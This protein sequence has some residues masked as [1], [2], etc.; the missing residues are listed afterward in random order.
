MRT[1]TFVLKVVLA[2]IFSISVSGSSPITTEVLN[3]SKNCRVALLAI[4]KPSTRT[5]GCIPT[6]NQN[7]QTYPKARKLNHQIDW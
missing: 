5:R 7:T 6:D 1:Q 4:S 3:F 2:T